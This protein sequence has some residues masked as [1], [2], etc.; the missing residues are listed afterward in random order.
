MFTPVGA[1]NT[2]VI[3]PRHP[4]ATAAILVTGVH[5]TFGG[6][7]GGPRSNAGMREKS[8]DEL[9]A[10]YG[11]R[12]GLGARMLKVLPSLTDAPEKLSTISGAPRND[13]DAMRTNM[14]KIPAKSRAVSYTHLTLPTICSV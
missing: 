3:E 5:P 10:L 12:T 4:D 14:T 6:V 1:L 7:T 2:P 13:H 11:A 8:A 9:G